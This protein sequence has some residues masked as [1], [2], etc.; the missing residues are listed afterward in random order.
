ML[1]AHGAIVNLRETN[2]ITALMMAADGGYEDVVQLLLASGADVNASTAGGESAL[3]LAREKGFRLII[4]M[5]KRAGAVEPAGYRPGR[6]IACD[7]PPEMPKPSPQ[8]NPSP[9][10]FRHLVSV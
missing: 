6:E 8:P 10:S 5:L 7:D 9:G 1:L 4:E 2:G 3:I